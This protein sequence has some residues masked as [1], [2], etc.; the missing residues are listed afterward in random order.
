[1]SASTTF[2]ALLNVF[3]LRP[4]TALWRELD[5][6]AMRSFVFHG[7]SLDI[8]CGDGIFSF[9]RAGG[10]FSPEFDAFRSM[11]GLDR[12]FDHVDVFDAY[13]AKLSP[14]VTVTPS[15]RIDFA[16]DHKAALLSKAGTLGLYG[17]LKQGD[18]NRTLPFED[19]SFESVFSN[20]LYWLN[21]PQEALKEIR[22]ILRPGGR[23]C[24][25]LPNETFPEYSFYNQLCVKT[26]DPRWAFLE[27]LDRGR[28]EVNQRQALP[29]SKWE[30]MF[31]RA[32][33]AVVSH[34]AH[35]SKTVVLGW[36][37]GLR[38]L[39]PVLHRMA[40][41]VAP[42]KLPEIKQEWVATLRQFLEPI[43]DMD[44]DLSP[45]SEPAFN[46][47]ILEKR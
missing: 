34:K 37:I 3:W 12:Y 23:V 24:L 8:G 15:Y 1:M 29:R 32:G 6:R 42:D 45:E 5:I 41:S 38:P 40:E 31:A 18:A 13:D 47:Y 44:D 16:F 30:A 9:I 11:S 33:L 26:G 28:L 17:A 35:L 20:I 43:A 25:M 14:T 39:F 36:D 27:K 22:R 19:E 4:E 7:P 10:R 21:E 2:D 46:C